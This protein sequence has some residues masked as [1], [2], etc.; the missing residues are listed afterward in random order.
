MKSVLLCTLDG[1]WGVIPE[2]FSF[3][4]PEIVD[5]H[6]HHPQREELEAT[7]Q[8]HTLRSP[9]A[10]WILTSDGQTTNTQVEL[11]S[12]WRE[13]LGLMKQAFVHSF[14]PAEQRGKLTRMVDQELFERLSE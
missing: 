2:V 7:R 11:L 14:L 13:A 12:A 10:L 1:S 3:L 4:A 8:Q 5:L 9:D 6:A